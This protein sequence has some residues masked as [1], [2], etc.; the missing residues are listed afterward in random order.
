MFD[1]KNADMAEWNADAE[2]RELNADE[3]DSVNGG[4]FWLLKCLFGGWS[5]KKKSSSY[6]APSYS[7][8]APSY[9]RGC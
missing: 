7:S 2:I 8:C 5:W 3:A 1:I 4:T 9:K 6:C